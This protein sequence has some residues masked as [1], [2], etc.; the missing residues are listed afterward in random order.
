MSFSQYLYVMLP[1]SCVAG[2]V[3]AALVGHFLP[4]LSKSENHVAVFGL[5][6]M[7]I[8]TVGAALLVWTFRGK[9]PTWR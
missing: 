3:S 6:L 2:L 1:F 8:V 9:L 5:A 7:L 4:A